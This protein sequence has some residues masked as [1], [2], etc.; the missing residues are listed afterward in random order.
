MQEKVRTQHLYI[1]RCRFNLPHPVCEEAQLYDCEK[2]LKSRKQ[3]YDLPRSQ[4][5]VRVNDYNPLI[6]LLW[7]ANV[8]IQ[9]IAESSQAL[10]HYV[11]GYVTKSERSNMQDV[12]QDISD[13]KS[14][15][16]K[17]WSFGLRCL[18]SRECGLYEASD[19]LLGDSL[20]SKSVT[21]Q[22]IDVSMLHKRNRRVKKAQ[23]S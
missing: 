7:K 12:W 15:Y 6:L 5:E 14:V 17:L 19:L 4:T 1:T 3:I 18:R 16:S 23:R 9:F 10:A 13:N 11:S 8:D 2:T 22:Y 20:C 21:V